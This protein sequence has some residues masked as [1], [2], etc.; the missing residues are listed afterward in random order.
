MFASS[1]THDLEVLAQLGGPPVVEHDESG[2]R[3]V[4]GDDGVGG[5]RGVAEAG[6]GD[7]EVLRVAGQPDVQCLLEA[8]PGVGGRALLGGA[9]RADEGV[10]A[11]VD[12]LHVGA[13]G[14]RIQDRVGGT[15]EFAVDEGAHL[16]DRGELPFGL[17]ARHLGECVVLDRRE[18]LRTGLDGHLAPSS[19]RV[20]RQA[21]LFSLNG[22]GHLADTAFHAHL[23][24]LVEFE[25]VFH[26][27]LAGDRL[28]EAAHD[29]RHGLVFGHAA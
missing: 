19:V 21:V 4:G 2:G 28:D 12:P 9:R 8:R 16:V 17:E 11:V 22:S 10:A 7:G 3:F 27:Q 14:L 1:S 5:P 29:H 25:R 18:A 26:G 15:V 24:E 23:D 13:G 20:L 6:A